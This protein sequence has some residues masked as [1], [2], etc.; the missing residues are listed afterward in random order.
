MKKIFASL[1]AVPLS[2]V[3]QYFNKN[4]TRHYQEYFKLYGSGVKKDRIYIPINSGI[5]NDNIKAPKEIVEY[6]D[7]KG[8]MV[9]SYAAGTA[10]NKSNGR[11]IRIGK[12]LEDEKVKS[13]YDGDSSR[14]G[15][16]ST[17]DSYVVI[18]R[19]PYD[20]VGISFDRGWSSCMNA[21]DGMYKHRIKDD[22]KEGSLVAYLV[23]N[24]DKNINRPV[25][26]ILLK[27]YVRD[28]DK[29][30]KPGRLYGTANKKF[31]EVVVKFC[32]EFNQSKPDGVYDIANVYADG[33]PNQIFKGNPSYEDFERADFPIKLY[34]FYVSNESH[35]QI[36]ATKYPEDVYF[37]FCKNGN[38]SFETLLHLS[39]YFTYN[40]LV[41]ARNSHSLS[42]KQ[43]YSLLV[44]MDGE[45][46]AEFFDNEPSSELEF[47]KNSLE[48]N[49]VLLKEFGSRFNIKNCSATVAKTL[50]EESLKNKKWGELFACFEYKKPTTERVEIPKDAV[51][52]LI[53]RYADSYNEGL[54]RSII[55]C[56]LVKEEVCEEILKHL[57]PEAILHCANPP[58]NSMHLLLE[59]ANKHFEKAKSNVKIVEAILEDEKLYA[60]AKENLRIQAYL[61]RAEKLN[62][63]SHIE[64]IKDLLEDHHI[65]YRAF[66][67]FDNN[68]TKLMKY[69]LK[70]MPEEKY[71]QVKKQLAS[72]KKFEFDEYR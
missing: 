39:P 27:P 66:I 37:G 40:S 6:L 17:T 71:Q 3:K 8:Y 1:S 5:S 15:I 41:N 33:E 65:P 34:S 54:L 19:H 4:F 43:V 55:S 30:L 52:F 49:R 2:L 61:L 14:K 20:I 35:I 59:V 56:T 36:L 12:L 44:N 13:I 28:N 58:K 68:P 53:E 67:L 11:T 10:R 45:E 70:R 63:S 60:K 46:I 26:R 29:I 21:K 16:K 72:T 51:Q 24:D 22:I 23:K 32:E 38:V 18:S 62:K 48:L 9:E 7:S 64:K 47:Y 50:L 25:A 57:E 42:K 69:I 31:R